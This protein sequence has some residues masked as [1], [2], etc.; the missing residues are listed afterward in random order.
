VTAPL[1]IGVHPP[2]LL[3]W[4]APAFVGEV[5]LQLADVDALDG[6]SRLI[7]RAAASHHAADLRA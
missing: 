6:V 5:A 2:D 1:V 7:A 4:P 3:T